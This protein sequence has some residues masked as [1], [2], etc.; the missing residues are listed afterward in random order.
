MKGTE[1]GVP[2]CWLTPDASESSLRS[3][4]GPGLS[5]ILPPVNSRPSA[6]GLS[7]ILTLPLNPPGN[8][9]TFLRWP[10]ATH[11]G[12]RLP[13]GRFAIPVSASAANTINQWK[14][15]Q[16]KLTQ[17]Q[18]FVIARAVSFV[19]DLAHDKRAMPILKMIGRDGS[20]AA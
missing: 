18:W 14:G 2:N 15:Y 1:P 11:P 12:G 9:V 3:S 8:R 19:G 4:S 13:R 7:A 20:K 5:A 16:M 10:D 17:D 6:S